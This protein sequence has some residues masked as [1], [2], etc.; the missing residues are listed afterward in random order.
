MK[1]PSGS[2]REPLRVCSGDRPRRAWSTRRGGAA[3]ASTVAADRP[4]QAKGAPPSAGPPASRR[5]CS[6]IRQGMRT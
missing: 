2:R 3:Y 1:S 6:T 4:S 5:S